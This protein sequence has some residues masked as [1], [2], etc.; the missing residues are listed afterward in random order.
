MANIVVWNGEGNWTPPGEASVVQIPEGQVCVIGDHY[1]DGLFITADRSA[2]QI[3]E[4][5][6]QIRARNEATRTQLLTNAGLEIDPLQ[7]A[8][9]L[10]M[11]TAE[12]K[13]LLLLWKKYRV[14]IIRME[15][16]GD[17]PVWPLPPT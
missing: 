7:D 15:I 14:S 9:D 16:T 17:Q 4:T 11:A 3:V 1:S 5:L 8:V 10:D 13:R 2:P 6:E 12:E